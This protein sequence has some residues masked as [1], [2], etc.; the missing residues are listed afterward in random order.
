MRPPSATVHPATVITLHTLPGTED[1][2][3]LSPFCMKVEVYLKLQ[4]LPYKAKMG[5]PRK[6]PKAK[7]PYI[8]M[9]GEII[10]DSSTILERLEK[11]AARPLDRGLD[12]ASRAQA[13]VLQ[14][15]LEESLYFTMV[16]SRW[17]DDEGWDELGPRIKAVVP[18]AVR[19]FLPGIMRKKVAGQTAAQGIGRHSREEIFARGKADIDAIAAILNDRPYL[20][21]NELRT[22][23]V[24][25]YA[26]LGNIMLWKKPS[27]LSE[28]LRSHHTLEAYVERI[29]AAKTLEKPATGRTS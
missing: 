18:A 26:F 21:G 4:K 2:E 15:M 28:A 19:W 3:S 29:R 20:L 23:D 24:I 7:L 8:E 10:A 5:D 13:H 25:A 6:A 12:A 9:D 14:R 11:S 16:W 27:P 22:I 1:I 17:V